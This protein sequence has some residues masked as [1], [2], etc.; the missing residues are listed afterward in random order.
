[1]DIDVISSSL[2]HSYEKRL[3]WGRSARRWGILPKDLCKLTLKHYLPDPLVFILYTCRLTFHTNASLKINC[4]TH[5]SSKDHRSSCQC[6]LCIVCVFI[7]LC[8]KEGTKHF[9][10]FISTCVIESSN[11]FMSPV[12]C[13]FHSKAKKLSNNKA[14][15]FSTS[16]C[17]SSCLRC[18]AALHSD[19]AA[20]LLLKN[21]TVCNETEKIISWCLFVSCWPEDELQPVPWE[22]SPEQPRDLVSDEK[23]PSFRDGTTPWYSETT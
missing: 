6:H 13:C 21:S 12:Y 20:F 14:L 16:C 2:S 9:Y 4:H 10:V 17:L 19:F 11:A 1:M 23:I 15:V 5:S 3:F 8:V 18:K 22:N 7:C